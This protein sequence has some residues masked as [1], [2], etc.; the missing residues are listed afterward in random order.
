[1]EECYARIRAVATGGLAETAFRTRLCRMTTR[2]H[3]VVVAVL[4]V[5]LT[6]AVAAQQPAAG[7]ATALP[8]PP[9]REPA[10]AFPVQAGSLPAESPEPKAIPGSTRRFTPAQIDD[11][12]NPPDWL[13]ESHPP[14]PGIVQKGHAG[15]LACGA[16]HLM[17]GFGHPESSDLTGFTAAYLVQQLEDFKR[18]TRHDYA[19][20]NGISKE[21]SDAEVREAAEWFAS[22][23]RGK[24]TRVVEAAMVPKTFVGQG[25]MRFLDPKGGTEPIGRRII[26]LPEDQTLARLRDPRSGFV[27]YVPPGS[28]ARGRALAAGGRGKTIACDVCHGDGA[29]GLANVPRLAGLHPIYIARQLHLFK[30]GGRA[31]ADAALM[32]RPVAALTDDDILNLSA[33]FGSLPPQ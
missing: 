32:K 20:M 33:Y 5:C 6:G 22:L 1:M 14:A 16:C 31:G 8:S 4:A 25:R 28:I 15:A 30:D 29:K 12:L 19:R 3:A 17:S 26:T 10:W 21:L 11:L 23:P 24:W 9:P 7:Q 18:G 27:A 13:P 2:L